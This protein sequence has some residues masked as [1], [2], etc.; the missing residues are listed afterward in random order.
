MTAIRTPA[1]FLSFDDWHEAAWTDYLPTMLAHGVK[2][3]F[4]SCPR[5]GCTDAPMIKSRDDIPYDYWIRLWALEDAGHT[6]GYHT[7][8]HAIMDVLPSDPAIISEIDEGLDWF[9]LSGLEPRHFAYPGGKHNPVI[10]KFLLGRFQTLRTIVPSDD[11]GA[12]RYYTPET[13]MGERIFVAYD[14]QYPGAF[15][16]VKTALDGN[17]IAFFF[18]HHPGESAAELNELY[19]LAEQSGAAFY[20]MSALE[21]G[22]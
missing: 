11:L 9:A 12:M 17:L 20:P 6:V 18:A 3:T 2:A 16:A 15:D 1:I 19:R 21:T 5:R 22:R 7:V 4:Y 14:L 10:D 8:N 13:V